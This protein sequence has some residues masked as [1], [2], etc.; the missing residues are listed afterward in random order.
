MNGGDHSARGVAVWALLILA[1]LA[2]VAALVVG[3]V[4]RA[5]LDSDQFAN[6]ATVGL[7]DSS[8]R[9]LIAERVTD[10]VVLANQSDL[11][12]ARP[13][14]E[15]IV[16][17]VIGGRAFT[18]V[19]R[20]GVRD[21]H[22][23]LLDH[24][25]Q[26]LTL[27]L[28]DVGTL[29][30]AG[31]TAVRPS[32]ADQVRA[33]GRV[34]LLQSDLTSVGADAAR[35]AHTVRVLAWLCLLVAV[36]AVAGAVALA[37]DRRRAVVR[38]GVGL[39]IAG[40]VL[41]VGLSVARTIAVDTVH[42]GDERDAVRAVWDAFL[43]DLRTAAWILA[44][45][46][47][48]VAAAAASLIKPVE[49][50]APLRRAWAWVTSEPTRAGWRVARAAALIAL[51]LVFLLARDTVIQVAFTLV[52]V[53]LVYAGVTALLELVYRPREDVA[54]A[55][56]EA[57][58]ETEVAA[59]PPS[60]R[61][62]ALVAAGVAAVAVAVAV[63]AFVGTG[64][65]ST[66]AP[67]FNE[68]DGH[69]ALCD[70]SLEQIALPATHN[71]MSAPLPG[72]FSS[73]QDHPI[74]QQLND[75]IRGLLIDTHYADRLSGGRLRTDFGSSEEL[76]AR[77][78]QDGVS[79]SA[80]DAALRV[81]ER[82]GFAGTGTR[83]MYVCHSFC[84]LGGTPLAD[85]L[86]DLH[87]FLVANPGEV[88][89]VIN[90]DYVTP[91]AFVGA[92]E[93]AGLGDLVYRGPTGRGQW[94]TLREMIKSNQR[95]VFLAENHAGAAPWYHPAYTSIT[96]ETP[97]AFSKV[98]QLTNPSATAASCRPNRG[99]KTA[100]LFLVNHWIT[101]DPVPRPS[102]ARKVN[103]YEPLLHRLRECQRI[104]HHIPNLV[105]VDFYRQGD[106]FKAVDAINGVG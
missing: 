44:A 100:P 70:R 38:L 73:Q 20:A 86:T 98:A 78:R 13:L 61:P 60:R 1:S 36:A 80:V 54:E 37:A 84:E 4:Q 16:S 69:E 95:V 10:E 18:G 66:A 32:L 52:G 2:V 65:T 77:A 97:F 92:V 56:S 22:R 103:A 15:S 42:G 19:F 39:A 51:G 30:A 91:R 31:V 35:A 48:V 102:N 3:Y 76:R 11:V 8:V 53:Y 9:A 46:G 105:A 85:V 75:G 62:R 57:E 7:R 34:E 27:T 49:I 43:G 89:V 12:A 71:A 96:E 50:D 25:Q 90:Q 79:E 63:G 24:D 58:T 72:W 74:A 106:L 33:T 26:T 45:S 23:A 81:R 41:V 64:G 68:C 93:K 21:A 94:P 55:D 40:V 47:A 14:I 67:V 82:L 104:R 87:D 17:S 83:G 99:P 29:V 5:A 59:A 28:G 88:V 101:T 6:R